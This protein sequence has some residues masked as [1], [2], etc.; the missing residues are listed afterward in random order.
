MV[1][2]DPACPDSRGAYHAHG[3]DDEDLRFVMVVDTCEDGA[4]AADLETG[5]WERDP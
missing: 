4:R 2:D 5:I 1:D 3:V